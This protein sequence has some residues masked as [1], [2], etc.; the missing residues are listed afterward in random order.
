MSC[1][2]FCTLVFTLSNA[3]NSWGA[4]PI[5]RLLEKSINN[6]G[7]GQHPF[8]STV[9]GGGLRHLYEWEI[10]PF[11]YYVPSVCPRLYP[12]LCAGYPFCPGV[13]R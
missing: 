8:L 7:I 1:A 3:D 10:P 9:W 6:A 12:V 2:S 11:V 5:I 13:V 4:P